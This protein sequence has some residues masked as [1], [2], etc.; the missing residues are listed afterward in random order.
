MI[1]ITVDG[2]N[3]MTDAMSKG[4]GIGCVAGAQDEGVEDARSQDSVVKVVPQSP[5][6][7][8]P[9]SDVI[10]PP[11]SDTGIETMGTDNSA[12][13]G[14]EEVCLPGS[15][16][17]GVD[18]SCRLV[19]QQGK[20]GRGLDDKG[21][22]GHESSQKWPKRR[23]KESDDETDESG[24]DCL[25]RSAEASRKLNESLR[26]GTFVVDEGKRG[27]FEEKCCQLDGHA[28]FC[29]K[30]SW[31]VRHSKC[32]TLMKMR[33][34][35]NVVRFSKHVTRKCKRMGE[36]G[37]DGTIDSFFK[38]RGAGEIGTTRMAKP[39]AWKQIVTGIRAKPRETLI[40]LIP[41]MSNERPCL[42]LGKD[43]V[44]RF[45]TYISC[46]ITEG[47]GS[48]SDTKITQMLFGPGVK[49]S[50]LDNDSKRYVAAA[51]IHMQKW[52]ISHTLGAVF[53][54]SCR[55]NVIVTDK[56]QNS[57]CDQCLG[58]LKLDV[59]KKAL[60]VQPPPLK[61]LKFTPH[62][63]RNAV[64]NLGMNLAKIEGFSSLLETVSYG[65][66]L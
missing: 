64:T 63:H 61:N 30:K 54:A 11:L 16:V 23:P 14:D 12:T 10:Q 44:E 31:K 51:R 37:R 15:G 9:F 36:K 59:F 7:S 46:V 2:T 52:K 60:G 66:R 39:L 57:T 28:K 22:G 58:L 5:T 48:C 8:T 25:S 20:R 17:A 6:P 26:S 56:T 4:K 27:R 34:P 33:E 55:G 45:G 49:Y 21:D 65:H 24:E 18:Q 40:P 42:G 35:Y 53:S 43:K 3:D 47:A 29:Y 32:P 1:D 62:R 19:A 13:S 41:F 50:Q 38:W